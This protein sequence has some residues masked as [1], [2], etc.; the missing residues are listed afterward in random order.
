MPLKISEALGVLT[1]EFDIRLLEVSAAGCLV[2]VSRRLE[3]GS[4][5]T[6]HLRF[7]T[8]EYDDDVQVA[9]CQAIRGAGSVYRVGMK[10][11][12]TPRHPRSIR[13]A[14]RSRWRRWTAV[15]ITP[16]VAG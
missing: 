10:F 16:I 7:G 1:R 6:L 13:Q 9:R 5:V 3:V 14:V 2:E 15:N 4:V 11:L 12:E 8:E